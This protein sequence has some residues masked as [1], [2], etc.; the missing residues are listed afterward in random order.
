MSQYV[1][2]DKWYISLL[3]TSAETEMAGVVESL[4]TCNLGKLDKTIRVVERTVRRIESIDEFFDGEVPDK[5]FFQTPTAFKSG[6][7]YQ[8]LP[9]Q[10]LLLQSLISKWN[11]ALGDIC[12]IEDA[13]DGVDALAQGLV[14]RAMRLDSAG[15]SVKKIVVPGA[16]GNI[17]VKIQSEGFSRQLIGALL[18]FGCYSGVGIKTTLGMGGFAVE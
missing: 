13:G 16:I 1:A 8:I 18:H 10:K 3:G 15:Y 6:G 4:D 14:Y 2:G 17:S 12:P 11:S 9:T 5:V 7:A